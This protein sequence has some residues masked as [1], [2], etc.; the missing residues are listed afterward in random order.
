MPVRGSKA[1]RRQCPLRRKYRPPRESPLNLMRLGALARRYTRGYA[2]LNPEV[3][4]RQRAE[5]G[6]PT[7]A[8]HLLGDNRFSR[9]RLRPKGR[10]RVAEA[11][12]AGVRVK[13]LL[14][15]RAVP[16]AFGCWP[17]KG[18]RS[19]PLEGGAARGR[20]PTSGVSAARMPALKL[21]CLGRRHQ[22]HI[23]GY[24]KL[25]LPPRQSRGNSLLD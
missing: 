6:L 10:S 16:G 7:A 20:R 22:R 25:L 9:K 4:P 1:A 21:T 5:P 2:N 18:A 8:D 23:P 12:S 14:P 24:V 3:E 15:F 13:L 17:L 11:W 19:Q